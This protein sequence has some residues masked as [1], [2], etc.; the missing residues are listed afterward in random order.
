MKCKNNKLLS[1]LIAFFIIIL[2]ITNGC[3][4]TLLKENQSAIDKIKTKW[5][6]DNREGIC[7]VTLSHGQKGA[8]ILHG[9]T[10]LPQAKSEIIKTLGKP[11]MN[12][13]DSI[14]VLPDSIRTPEFKGV[15]TLS[16]INLRKHPDHRSELV[17]Q[18]ILGTPLLILKN[19]NSWLMIQ[20]PDRYIAW[21]ESS[22]VQLMTS[23]EFKDWQKSERVMFMDNSGW[24]YTSNA[25]KVVVG[26]VVAGSILKKGKEFSGYTQVFLPDGRVGFINN[27]KLMSFQNWKAQ[28]KCNEHN[29]DSVAFQYLGLPYLWGGTSTKGV[30]C[31]GFVQSVFFRNGLILSRDA[32]LQAQ[33][34]AQVNI[35]DSYKQLRNGDLLFFGS[36]ENSKLHVTHVAIYIGDKKYINSSGRV[37]INSLD[38]G[39]TDYIHSRESS[40]LIARRIIGIKNDIGIVPVS[41]HSWY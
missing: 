8:V 35:S 6:P 39:S 22:S 5:L 16:V 25:E 31:S 36:K 38:S 12:L 34:G 37:M 10:T 17:S 2:L 4:S 1:I 24:I 20:T 33:H 7:S 30:D 26:D 11:G 13:I 15:V 3:H 29:I 23:A 28:V 40:F 21:T 32:S 41:D 18:A 14:I 9:E 19:E 27:K